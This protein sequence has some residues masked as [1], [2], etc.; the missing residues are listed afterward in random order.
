MVLDDD[1]DSDGVEEREG[2][3]MEMRVKVPGGRGF[4]GFRGLA[5]TRRERTKKSERGIGVT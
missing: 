2:Y 5:E 1:G 3:E 4:S